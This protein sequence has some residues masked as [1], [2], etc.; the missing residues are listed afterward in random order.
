MMR[1]LTYSN[2]TGVRDQDVDF[3]LSAVPPKQ[4]YETLVLLGFM[5]LHSPAKLWMHG[6]E[7]CE[8]MWCV[9]SCMA[10]WTGQPLLLWL[11]ISVSSLD[12]SPC[13]V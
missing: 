13:L 12:P 8:G 9:I 1:S 2:S 4:C 5:P 7:H 10:H 11:M 6:C 3:T